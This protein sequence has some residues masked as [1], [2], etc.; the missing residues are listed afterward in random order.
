MVI[1]TKS[2][3]GCGAFTKLNENTKK[4]KKIKERLEEFIENDG[5]KRKQ[6]HA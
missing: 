5:E 2:V 1:G 4:K 6:G 3:I